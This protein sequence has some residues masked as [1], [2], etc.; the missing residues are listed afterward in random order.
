MSDKK[1][2]VG[3][4]YTTDGSIVKILPENGK[5]FELKELQAAV[6]GYIESLISG[7]PGCRQMYCNED[8]MTK[9]L[10]GNPHTWS[11][12]KAS[13]YRLNGYSSNWRV[14]GNIFAVKKELP[15]ESNA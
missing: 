13:V 3:Y 4:L 5:S 9:N 6:G 1:I 15:E 8:G 7:I 12:V 14:Q 11:V 2:Q 10:P